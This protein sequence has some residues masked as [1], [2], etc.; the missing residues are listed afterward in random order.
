MAKHQ[1]RYQS[2]DTN[3]VVTCHQ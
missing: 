1:S 2:A 3:I